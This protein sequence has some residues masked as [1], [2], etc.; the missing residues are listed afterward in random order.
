MRVTASFSGSPGDLTLPTPSQTLAF[1]RLHLWPST[2][3]A[4]SFSE[5]NPVHIPQTH[6]DRFQ[7]ILTFGEGLSEKKE[8]SLFLP[9]A[10]GLA[11]SYGPLQLPS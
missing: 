5:I 9:R 1:V 2:F 7:A 4:A 3:F 11:C 8:M 6:R 10:P